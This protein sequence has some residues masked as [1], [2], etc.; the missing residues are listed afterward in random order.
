MEKFNATLTLSHYFRLTFPMKKEDKPFL[1][2][3]PK[4]FDKIV[5]KGGHATIYITMEPAVGG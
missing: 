2:V 1:I 4:A 3:S 5:H